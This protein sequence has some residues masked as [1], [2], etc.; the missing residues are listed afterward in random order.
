M[1]DESLPL[2]PATDAPVLPAKGKGPRKGKGAPPPRR[3]RGK[4]RLKTKAAKTATTRAHAAKGAMG[5]AEPETDQAGKRRGPA[6]E[7]YVRFRLHVE[8]GETSIVDSHLV[9]STLL[10]PSAIHGNFVYEVTEAGRRLH[11][12]SIPDLGVVRSFANPN[13]P[14]EER[15]HHTYELSTYEFDV[16]V[17]AKEL[18]NAALPDVV[19]ALYRVKEL[20]PPMVL[21]GMPLNVQF[22]REL[23]EVVWLEGIPAKAV[24]EE[25]QKRKTKP[26]RARTRRRKRR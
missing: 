26:E 22:Q 17:P 7:G 6:P 3:I 10:Q 18:A 15:A 24:P 21:G 20:R 13:G 11:V 5:P 4:L 1:S 14:L 12:D 19:I 8:N 16:R 2:K 25:L 23:R 9:E